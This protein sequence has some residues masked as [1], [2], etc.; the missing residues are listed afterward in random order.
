[1]AEV[2][3]IDSESVPI[4]IRYFDITIVPATIFFFNT[5][6]IKVDYGTPDHTKFIGS[7]K[8]K[9]D[10]IDLVEMIYRGVM[11]G[12]VMIRSPIDPRDIAKYDLV[13]KDI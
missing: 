4:Y 12:K 1:M 9:E 7:F 13:Y 10:L 8:K 2:Y 5:E 11:K 3:C 6:H